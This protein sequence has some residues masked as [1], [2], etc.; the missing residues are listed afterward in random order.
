[1]ANRLYTVV[2]AAKS[3]GAL[4]DRGENGS[5]GGADIQVMETLLHAKADVS[6]IGSNV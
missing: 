4:T 1:M 3:S 2:H 6:G 5:I